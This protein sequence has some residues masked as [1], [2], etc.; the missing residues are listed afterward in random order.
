MVFDAI[1]IPAQVSH[2]LKNRI[3]NGKLAVATL[4][5]Y[6]ALN[7][8]LNI[9]KS[10]PTSGIQVK[11]IALCVALSL[12]RSGGGMVSFCIFSSKIYSFIASIS[13][14]SMRLLLLLA[15][16]INLYQKYFTLSYSLLHPTIPLFLATIL[17]PPV[18]L[19]L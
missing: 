2:H 14:G 19:F 16:I 10:I 4:K 3:P 18:R 13:I 11:I 12:G 9:P 15:F 1:I 5:Y 7:I 8:S 17:Y 6:L